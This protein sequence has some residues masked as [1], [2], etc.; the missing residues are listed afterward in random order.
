MT[1]NAITC[2][3]NGKS[4]I[5]TRILSFLHGIHKQKLT[6][7]V[8]AAVVTNSHF[9]ST[10]SS[11]LIY[12]IFGSMITHERNKKNTIGTRIS[13]W[14]GGHKESL[15]YGCTSRAPCFGVRVE[16]TVEFFVGVA[17]ARV[18][19]LAVKGSE[20]ATQNS[21]LSGIDTGTYVSMS[22]KY[23]VFW[24]IPLPFPITRISSFVA[25]GYEEN[26]TRVEFWL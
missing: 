9:L 11:D 15:M 14:R 16:Y 25:E 6:S 4:N 1:G 8:A 26:T 2:E 12:C 24:S 5:C 18:E 22:Q 7:G 17:V 19:F 13:S 3:P 10:I 20:N 21:T 23:V